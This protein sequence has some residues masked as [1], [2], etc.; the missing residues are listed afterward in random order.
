MAMTKSIITNELCSYGCNNVAKFQARNFKLICSSSYNKCPAVRLKNSAGVAKAHKE[1]K[2][3]GWNKLAKEHK[4][5]RAWAKN[6]DR[7]DKR[8]RNS[9]SF[10]DLFNDTNRSN[11]F[12]HAR[13][14]YLIKQRGHLCENCLNSSWF[15]K[16]ITLELEH[17]DGNKYNNKINNLKLLCPNCHSQTP[18]WRKR[19]TTGKNRKYTDEEMCNCILISKNMNE[20]LIK[21]NLSWG[22]GQTILKMMEK[23]N[24]N[25]GDI[26]KVV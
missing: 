14:K 12:N 3:P 7:T 19:K 6:L 23:Y 4:L 5:N 20:C 21:L 15:T 22:S 8:I 17:V 11:G 2:I 25:F 13:R 10:E 24:I 18:T 1:G 9:F 16:P 26:G